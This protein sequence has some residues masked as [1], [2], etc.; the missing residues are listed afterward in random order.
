[1]FVSPRGFASRLNSCLQPDINDNK[2]PGVGHPA[3]PT[4]DEEEIVQ[5]S[6]EIPL[7]R[8]DPG[9][10][11]LTNVLMS[12][13]SD[14]SIFNK[15]GVLAGQ[16][17]PP[18]SHVFSSSSVTSDSSLCS[19]CS[20]DHRLRREPDLR[21]V[22]HPAPHPSHEEEGRRQLRP[23]EE[24]HLQESSNHRDLRV[25]LLLLLHTHLPISASIRT[26]SSAE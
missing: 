23:R 15:T 19:S 13:A 4:V 21:R 1:M 14:N 7:L 18:V 20:S 25:D 17:R 9:E 6:N 3:R 16:W 12:H 24:T 26:S 11:Q 10:E 22:P 8:N 5:N 2:I